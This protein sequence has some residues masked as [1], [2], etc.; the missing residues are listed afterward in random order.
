MKGYVKEM[1]WTSDN[2]KKKTKGFSHHIDGEK[3]Y[4]PNFLNYEALRPNYSA[5]RRFIFFPTAKS[6]THFEHSGGHWKGL[7]E[8]QILQPKVK[9]LC[10]VDAI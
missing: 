4:N 1:L 8:E 5:E 9:E 7:M 6:F 3:D 2:K 10:F